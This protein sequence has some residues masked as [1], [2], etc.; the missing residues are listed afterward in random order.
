MFLKILTC[1]LMY[2]FLIIP[3]MLANGNWKEADYDFTDSDFWHYI[4]LK[5][6]TNYKALEAKLDAFSQRHFQGTK[7]SGSIEK[8][9]LQPLTK[10]HLYSDY[11][12]EIGKTGKC[13]CC[14]GLTHYCSINYHYC[15]GK[16]C[17]SFYCKIIGPGKGSRHS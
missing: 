8:F 3:Y 15:M 10:A 16:L 17:K 9:H 5:H 2:W 13:Y 6:G 12:Y 1:S 4:Q 11:E 7:V 14:L